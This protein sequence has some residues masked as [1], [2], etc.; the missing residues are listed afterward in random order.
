[1]EQDHYRVLESHNGKQGVADITLCRPNVVLLDLGLADIKG[2]QVLK[3]LRAPPDA[4]EAD[5]SIRLW[6]PHPAIEVFG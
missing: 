6:F 3:N 5:Q 4:L 2:V 1:L